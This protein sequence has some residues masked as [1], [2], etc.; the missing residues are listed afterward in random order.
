MKTLKLLKDWE[1]G[2]KTYKKDA[3]LDI[4]SDDVAVGLISDG[5]ATEYDEEAAKQAKEIEAA[6]AT[7]IK[8]AVK[9]AVKEIAEKDAKEKASVVVTPSE[10]DKK[11]GF[12]GMWEFAKHVAIAAKLGRPTDKLKTFDEAQSNY[13]K[14]LKATGVI[15]DIMQEGDDA[16]GGFLVP[17]EFRSTLLQNALENSII[18]SRA[19]FIPMQT[20]RIEM[21]AIFDD[22]HSGGQFFGGV[23]IK[24]I[25]EGEQK[26]RS[27]PRFGKVQLNL[28]EIAGLCYVSNSLLEDSP[29]SIEPLLNN[30]FGQAIQFTMDDDFINGDGA[31]KPQGILNAAALIQ[32]PR[33]TAAEINVADILGMWQRLHPSLRNNAIWVA[34]HGTFV[35]LASMVLGTQPVYLPM[36]SVAGRP[37]ETLMGRPIFYSEK[38]PALGDV[39][40]IL[41]ADP[42]QYLVGGKT[43]LSIQAES[44]MH[45]RFDYDEMAY[46]FVIRYD[47]VSWW[48]S[49]MTPKNGPTVSPFVVL[50]EG[51]PQ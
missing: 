9:E 28:H 4:S 46:R 41:L 42:K 23:E 16:Q 8:T 39:G 18:T 10:P 32:V 29:I 15:K 51:E 22:D 40:D 12:V 48:R 17:T 1:N 6:Q 34:N 11:G 20:N 21:P 45:L 7:I 25:A 33:D 31:G 2:G 50:D 35:Q 26:T 5:T 24:R 37:Y 13:L 44:S 19:T 30:L 27:K 38:M 47:G 43:G 3:V 36:N 14:H 49:A